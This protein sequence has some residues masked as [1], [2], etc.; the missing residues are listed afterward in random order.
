MQAALSRHPRNDISGKGHPVRCHAA[1]LLV[2]RLPHQAGGPDPR[3]AALMEEQLRDYGAMRLFIRYCDGS[4]DADAPTIEGRT[5][6]SFDDFVRGAFSVN[7]LTT[8]VR[9]RYRAPG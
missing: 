7:T 9:E 4:P 3:L 2:L 1:W 8:V 5:I 6:V